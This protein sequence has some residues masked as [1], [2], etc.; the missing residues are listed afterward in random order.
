MAFSR[1]FLVLALVAMML[2]GAFADRALL[3]SSST[4]K[5]DKAT[6]SGDKA[7]KSYGKGSKA[8]KYKCAKTFPGCK[9]CSGS[10]DDGSYTCDSCV[11]ANSVFNGE[12]CVCDSDNGYGSI[13]KAQ[14]KAWYKANKGSKTKH[15]SKVSKCVLCADYGLEASE[16]KCVA[17]ADDQ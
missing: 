13:T 16:G 3:K 15:Y 1:V 10:D 9:T 2:V 8:L 5:A 7:T 12:A 4:D 6:K 14:V 11:A 17:P